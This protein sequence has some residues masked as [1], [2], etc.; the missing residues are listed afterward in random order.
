[1]CRKRLRGT[2]IVQAKFSVA[3]CPAFVKTKPFCII[4]ADWDSVKFFLYSFSIF[5]NSC[6][7]G[8]TV[9]QH[10]LSGQRNSVWDWHNAQSI[11]TVAFKQRT[12]L[13]I[14]LTNEA[15]RAKRYPLHVKCN[16]VNAILLHSEHMDVKLHCVVPFCCSACIIARIAIHASTVTHVTARFSPCSSLCAHQPLRLQ[17]S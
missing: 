3:A 7:T 11:A 17:Q 10:V 16:F 6:N 4:Y 2:Y 8:C 9:L 14:R 1:M 12:L 13:L 15:M 5:C